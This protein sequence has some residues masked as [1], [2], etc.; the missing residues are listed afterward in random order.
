MGA[1]LF[2]NVT[3]QNDWVWIQDHRENMYGVLRGHLPPRLI[4][5][6]TIRSGYMQQDTVYHLAGVQLMSVVELRTS[7][8]CTLSGNRSPQRRYPRA[9]NCGY[10]EDLRSGASHTRD[11]PALACQQSDQFTHV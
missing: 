10:R 5:L 11:R 4:A 8:R 2:R 3:R 1:Q 6:F 7:V 9:H